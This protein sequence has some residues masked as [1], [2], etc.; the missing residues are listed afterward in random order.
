[1]KRLSFKWY[2]G[3]LLGLAYVIDGLVIV[4]SLGNIGTSLALKVALSVSR[5][6]YKHKKT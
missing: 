5:Y 6:N 1:M 2:F 4:L 3:I